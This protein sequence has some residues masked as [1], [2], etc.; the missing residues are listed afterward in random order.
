MG[1]SAPG[2]GRGLPCGGTHTRFCC[3][4]MCWGSE[5]EPLTRLFLLMNTAKPST[6]GTRRRKM[7]WWERLTVG[8]I[9]TTA[10][11]RPVLGSAKLGLGVG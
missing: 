7:L 9:Y 2:G 1:G 10:Q 3:S 8:P 5:L 11:A 4:W 6:C